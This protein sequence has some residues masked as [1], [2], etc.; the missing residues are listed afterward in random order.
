ME[1]FLKEAEVFSSDRVLQNIADITKF[2]RIQG[3]KEL[4][5]AANYVLED[6]R[7]WGIE[8]ELLEDVYDGE[9][10]HLTLKSPIAWDLIHGEIEIGERKATTEKTPLVVMAHSPSGEAEG[11]VVL[12]EREEDWEKAKDRIVLVGEEWRENYEKA[13]KS[14]AK[15]FIIYR[16][17]T[18][19]AFPYVG[20]FLAKEDLE[21]AKIPAVAISEE[22]ANEV[23]AKLKKGESVE[24]RLKVV[25][26]IREKQVLPMVYAK[27]GKPPYILFTAHLCH[28]KPGANDNASGSAALLELARALSK[29]YDESFRFGFAFLWIPEYHGTQ[30]FIESF[31]ELEHYYVVINLDMVGGREGVVMLIRTPLSRFSVIEGIMEYYLDLANSRG[32]SFGGSSLPK[33]PLKSYPYEMGSDHDVFSFFGIPSVMPITW[34]DSFYHSSEDSIEKLSKET[35]E[36]IGK[37]VL[38]TA[39]A[40]A[41]ASKEELQR[42]AKAYAMKYLGELG[43]TN[44]LDVAEKLVMKGLARDG[45]FLGVDIGHEFESN[46]WLQ[47]KQKGILS[48][49]DIMRIDKAQGKEM[50]ELLKER[51]LMALL[52]ELLMLGELLP[53]DDAFKALE[54]EYGKFK[55]ESLEKALEILGALN[56]VSFL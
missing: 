40:L 20:L 50:R 25:S 38:A 21:W 35:L 1:R 42:F 30:A 47:W 22:W 41:K 53:K 48:P 9:R 26:E 19:K 27:V 17:G 43:L 32:K 18:G 33:V 36:I 3:S 5:E 24:A 31:A 15:G 39:L 34:P 16:K 23:I 8:A 46:P 45:H 49:R 29:L 4:F 28:P 56:F 11:E 54:E 44:E 12:I 6:L 13:N 14:G 55:R 51:P 52:H 10:W 2:H 7:I 37:A